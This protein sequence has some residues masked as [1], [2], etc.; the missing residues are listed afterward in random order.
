MN[1]LPGIL[2]VDE[3]ETAAWQDTE[4]SSEDRNGGEGIVLDALYQ[5]VKARMASEA[6]S[7]GQL[8]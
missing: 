5:A 2:G 3:A 7:A 6:Q 1:E 8:R 4:R